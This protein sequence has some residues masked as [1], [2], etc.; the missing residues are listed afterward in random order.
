MFGA[1]EEDL[2]KCKE[3]LEKLKQYLL[4][5]NFQSIIDEIYILED[6]RSN[7]SLVD[8]LKANKEDY[9]PLIEHCLNSDSTMAFF[10][11]ICLR[12]TDKLKNFPSDD[13]IAFKK[14][15]KITPL[16]NSE[17]VNQKLFKAS[18]LTDNIFKTVITLKPFKNDPQPEKLADYY[19]CTYSVGEWFKD[20]YK[21]DF[22]KYII[23]HED[24][25]WFMSIESWFTQAESFNM[26]IENAEVINVSEAEWLD[27][28]KRLELFEYNLDCD[29]ED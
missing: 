24:R 11:T 15:F 26:Q 9:F 19:M 28:K 6:D 4:D 21:S 12:F 27:A 3:V 18:P 14:D 22:Y 8:E 16:G 5:D 13:C 23:Y 17:R 1:S 10:N 29:E 25:D 2:K 7:E 20:Y